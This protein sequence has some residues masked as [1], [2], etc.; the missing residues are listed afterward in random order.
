MITNKESNF[1]S[2][3]VYV[4]NNAPEL[5]T[6]MQRLYKQLDD[7]FNKYEIIC[8]ND[9]ST[10]NSTQV[11]TEFSKNI[12]H[13]TISL[14]NMSFHQGLEAS[15][16]AGMDLTI[17]DFVF[18]FDYIGDNTPVEKMCDIY[19]HSL[20]GY[21][22]V[23]AAPRKN[24]KLLHRIFYYL[25]NRFSYLHY[26]V[27]T[28]T[29]RVISR[30]A[31]NRCQSLSKFIPY[32]KAVYAD[33]GLKSDTIYYEDLPAPNNKENQGKMFNTAID[34]LILFTSIA[35]KCTIALT[36]F[37]MFTCMLAFIY[38][39]YVYIIGKPVVGWTTTMLFL[40]FGF[41]N[42]FFVLGM[43]MKYQAVLISIVFKNKPYVTQSIEKL[44]K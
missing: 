13:G 1:V 39:V 10:D 27:K 3:V 2:V 12:K 36:L 31:I 22:I 25:F 34:S 42:I 18:E 37:F 17:G 9:D 23:S 29:F 43:I 8:V 38:T 35:N 24:T 4:Y 20:K 33:S 15:M 11:L 19:Q 28:E 21:D 14:I 26:Q 30:R 44:T 41:F 32:R 7:N 6:F 5:S 40:S 16:N